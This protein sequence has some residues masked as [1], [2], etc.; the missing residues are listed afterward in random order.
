M[1]TVI[2][3]VAVFDGRQ[4][5]PQLSVLL[6]DG[7][8]DE[9]G[10]PPAPPGAEVV[11]G[12][13]RTL[14]P[15]LIDA[16]THTLFRDEL[17]Q[18]L[19]F[20]VTTVLDMFNAP[21]TAAA[22]KR[23]AASEPDL[24]DLRSAGTGATAPGGHPSD[25]VDAG[26]FPPF[27]AVRAADEADDFVAARLAE[28]SDYIKLIVD[29]G[30]WLATPI[31][32]LTPEQIHALV[33]AAHDRGAQAI[34]HA[35]TRPEAQRALAAGVD[36]LAHVF[37]DQPP[38]Q[39]FA[40]D[41]ARAGAFVVPT[42][43]VWEAKFG[44]PRER[45]LVDDPRVHP[46]L[47][48]EQREHLATTGGRAFGVAEP[49]W[50]GPTWA[51]RA[52]GQLHAA[53]VPLL[54]GSDAA[55]PHSAHGLALHAELLALVDAGLTPAEALAAATAGPAAHFDLHD[56]GRIAPG[57]RAD[58]VLVAGDPTADITAATSIT[59]VWRGG[60]RQDRGT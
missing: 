13:G 17:R 22:L 29:D 15:G 9:L 7:R 11:S 14:L 40:A 43:R 59:G 38:P 12:A 31:P 33:A 58:L 35:S 3:D 51:H 34:A 21:E 5:H 18:A 44:H 2:R 4:R 30:T 27:P 46:H 48:A 10:D 32:T 28:G 39:H 25:L 23:A 47:T 26:L 55:Y 53:N 52:T 57:Y 1:T 56:R 6:R 42:L 41:V 60:V 49:D 37:V 24:A 20:G 36:G 54:A 45:A 8:I 19:T 50:P 16:H